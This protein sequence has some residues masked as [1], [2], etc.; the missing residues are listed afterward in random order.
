[1]GRVTVCEN[2]LLK[3]ILAHKEVGSN[4]RLEIAANCR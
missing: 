3:R 2:R 1:M 4:R